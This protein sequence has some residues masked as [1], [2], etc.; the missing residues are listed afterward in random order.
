M[1]RLEGISPRGIKLD[2][3]LHPEFRRTPP[4]TRSTQ[5][6]DCYAVRLRGFERASSSRSP[7]LRLDQR[8][9]TIPTS[10][11]G[12]ADLF[13]HQ[14]HHRGEAHHLLGLAAG[15]EKTPVLDLLAY[16]RSAAPTDGP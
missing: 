16:Q 5:D 7:S 10:P 12:F 9:A 1:S 11:P 6:Q 2:E 8:R 15:Q 14:T 4:P 3:M 13:T